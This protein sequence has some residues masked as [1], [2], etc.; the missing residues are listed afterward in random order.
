MSADLSCADLTN[1][2]L[3]YVYLFGTNLTGVALTDAI[4]SNTELQN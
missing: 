1:G 3:V 2:E 4:F